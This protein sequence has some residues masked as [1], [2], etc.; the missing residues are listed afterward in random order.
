MKTDSRGPEPGPT[1]E[2][3]TRHAPFPF[4]LLWASVSAWVCVLQG[5]LPVSTERGQDSAGQRDQGV[6]VSGEEA[7]PTAT[8]EPAQDLPFPRDGDGSTHSPTQTGQCD[9]S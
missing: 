4:V 9:K 3:T 6:R 2:T 7:G 1:A 5:A 8:Q